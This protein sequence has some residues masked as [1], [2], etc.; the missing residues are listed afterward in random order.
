M[1]C[2]SRTGHVAV[3]FGVQFHHVDR[4]GWLT[5]TGGVDQNRQFVA[6]AG[7]IV[8]QVHAADAVVDHSRPIRNIHIGQSAYHLDAEPVVTEE[9]VP[10]PGDQH[11]WRHSCR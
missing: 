1:P 6:G 5:A 2:A 9:D 8:G 10:D 11:R 7:E 3:R 4:A